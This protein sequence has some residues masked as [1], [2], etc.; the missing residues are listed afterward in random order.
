[1]SDMYGTNMIT[2]L[3]CLYCGTHK[4]PRAVL[5]AVD[6]RTFGAKIFQI[7]DL[8]FFLG[9]FFGKQEENKN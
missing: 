6:L 5:G 2:H 9:V 3:W 8:F 1:M 4:I 7:I